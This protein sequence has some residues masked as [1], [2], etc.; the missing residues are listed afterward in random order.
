MV[1]V[2]ITVHSP[3]VLDNLGD[4]MKKIKER[5]LSYTAQGMIRNLGRNSPVDHGLLRKWYPDTISSDEITI[6]TP[7]AYAKYVNDGTGI[8][9]QYRTPIIHPSI[10][11][12]FA[13]EAGG[14]MVYTRMIRGQRG[15]KFVER[16]MNET[17]GQLKNFYIKAI[18]EVL[19]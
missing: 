4:S 17:R 18:H 12:K 1:T 3:S 10:G 8:Y 5:G 9:G 6:K 14:K 19:G 2:Y 15:Q 11:K 7:A 16:S 13:F